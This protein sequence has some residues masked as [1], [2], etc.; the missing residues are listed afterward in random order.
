MTIVVDEK[1]RQLFPPSVRRRA[2]IKIGDEL[3]VKVSGGVITM[4][5]KLPTADDE[6][7]PEQR[8]VI[9]ARLDEAEK[10]PYHG[11]FKSG[12]ELA[13]YMKKFKAQRRVK[14][15]ETKRI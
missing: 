2:G 1:T 12:E 3:E 7:T 15:I 10:G 8:R 14:T 6:Y 4:L 11:P 5:P 9:S 13:A